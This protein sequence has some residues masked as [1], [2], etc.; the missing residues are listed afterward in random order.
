MPEGIPPT[1]NEGRQ[2]IRSLTEKVLDK[3]C[4]D[5]TW[6]QQLLDDPEAAFQ[7]ANFPEYERLEEMRRSAQSSQAGADVWGQKG[8]GGDIVY[9][10][11]SSSL[12]PG[13]SPSHPAGGCR[14]GCYQTCYFTYK[15]YTEY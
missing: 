2:L 15:V 10:L 7:V 8:F 13:E 12:D 4:S 6:K 9:D 11:S 14:P 5:P 1:P 3:A